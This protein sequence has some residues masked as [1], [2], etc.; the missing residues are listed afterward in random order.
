MFSRAPNIPPSLSFIASIAISCGFARGGATTPAMIT[1]CSA[2]G[3]SI[4]Y[5]VISLRSEPS[6][7][8]SPERFR[9]STRQTA[10]PVSASFPSASCRPRRSASSCLGATTCHGTSRDLPASVSA[11]LSLVPE[12]VSGFPYGCPAPYNSARQ[13]SQSQCR[14]RVLFAV[15]SGKLPVSVRASL[16]SREKRDAKPRPQTSRARDQVSTSTPKAKRTTD[17]G[18]NTRAV[19]APSSSSWSLICERVTRARAVGQHLHRQVSC[20][21]QPSMRRKQIRRRPP[22]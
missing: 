5:T 12:P 7:R 3:L 2:P 10:S 9:S 22:A 17:Q 21:R 13:D 11:T 16:H 8:S 14:G 1:D 20:S 18:W 15:D 4:R 6:S 19:V